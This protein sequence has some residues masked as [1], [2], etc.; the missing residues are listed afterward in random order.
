VGQFFVRH[1]AFPFGGESS[2]GTPTEAVRRATT[3][4]TAAA[5]N[6]TRTAAAATVPAG[7]SAPGPAASAPSPASCPQIVRSV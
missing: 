5:A 7:A 4:C 3:H 1:R 2:G 6:A